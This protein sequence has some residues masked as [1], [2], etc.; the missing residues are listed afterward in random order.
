M[1]GLQGTTI[2]KK[3]ETLQRET[4][5]TLAIESWQKAVQ[6]KCQ[7]LGGR[8]FVVHDELS[9]DAYFVGLQDVLA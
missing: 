9:L 4:E 2:Q 1:D 3:G 6:Q 5:L 7:N 8:A